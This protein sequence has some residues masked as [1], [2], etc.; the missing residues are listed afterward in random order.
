[1]AVKLAI[2]DLDGTLI[3]AYS[4]ITDSFNYTMRK[5]GLLEKN[6]L[7]IRKAVGWGDENLLRPYVSENSRALALAIYRKHHKIALLKKTCLLPYALQ[8]LFFLKKKRIKMAV[9]SNRPT[10]FSLLILRHFKIKSCFDYILCADKLRHGKPHPEILKKILKKMALSRNDSVYIGDM[11]I[12]AEAGR[13]AKIKT[14]IVLGGSSSKKEIIKEKPF[15]IVGSLKAVCGL[16]AKG[17]ELL[18]LR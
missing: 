6:A 17:K 11:A 9:A 2:F 13:R 10:Q 7:T 3:D 8:T 12:D 18:S 14:I 1:M 5:L 4:A 16:L 15:K